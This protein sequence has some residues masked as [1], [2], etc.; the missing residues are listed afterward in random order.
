MSMEKTIRKYTGAFRKTLEARR[1]PD[2]AQKAAS[3][4]VYVL[5]SVYAVNG[6][7]GFWPGFCQIF[8]ILSIMNLIYRLIIDEYWVGHTRDW[9]IPGT[10]DMMPYI[11][12]KD[13]AV[14]WLFGTVGFAGISAL[15]S[16]I[17]TL[18]V[19]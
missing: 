14:K 18:K 13:K 1:I 15:L 4:L 3:Y 7:R 16:W 19:N 17:V 5:V 12:S 6:A 2:A 8:A 11:N 10:E 9:V